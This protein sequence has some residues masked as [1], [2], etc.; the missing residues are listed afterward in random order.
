M[1]QTCIDM[2]ISNTE[3]VLYFVIG[4]RQQ[5]LV[6]VFFWNLTNLNYKN[7]ENSLNIKL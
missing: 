2:Y 7:F 5:V 3:S 1:K 6:F 4:K